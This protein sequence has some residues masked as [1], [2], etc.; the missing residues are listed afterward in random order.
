VLSE[1]ARDHRMADINPAHPRRREFA[2][3]EYGSYASCDL[4]ARKVQLAQLRT[5]RRFLKVTSPARKRR[6]TRRC[7][8]RGEVL[9]HGFRLDRDAVPN[10]SSCG[11]PARLWV[12]P[13]RPTA[14]L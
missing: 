9:R 2:E 12:F 13:D 14:A 10:G 4:R 7:V 5:L 1:G 8:G 3:H 6:S 11:Q